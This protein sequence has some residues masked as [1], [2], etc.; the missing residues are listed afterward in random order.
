MKQLSGLDATFLYLESPQTPMHVGG[1]HLYALPK[2]FKGDFSKVVREH[3]RR[4]LHLAPIFTNRLLFMPFD[5]GHP[6]WR[7]DP[8][9]DLDYHIRR[10]SLPKPGTLAQLEAACAKLHMQLI[11]R[12]RPLWEFYVFTGLKTKQIGFYTKVHHAA[13]DG[14][15][16][17]ALANAVLDISPKPRTVAPRD[18]SRSIKATP[19][20]GV[21]TLL[22]AAF[23]NTLAQYAKI[24]RSLPAAASAISGAISK[25]SGSAKSGNSI[26]APRTVFNTSLSTQRV[27][28]TA[29]M[30]LSRAKSIGKSLEASLN[31]VV[32]FVCST[33][34][35]NYLLLH[36]ALPRKS[37]VAAMPVSLRAAGDKE[38]NNQSSMMLVSLGT[39]YAEPKRRLTAI[40]EST[41]KIKDGLQKLKSLMPTD[42]PSLLAPW[43]VGGIASAYNRS[44]IASSLPMPANVVISNVPGPT[45][46]LFLAGAQML[47]FHPVSIIVH[48]IALNITVQSYAGSIDFGLIACKKA[49]PDL[50]KL[51]AALND[52]LDELEALV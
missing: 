20:P 45:A 49:V 31:D 40:L 28:V 33:A 11:D 4:R 44:G 3:I 36:D 2:G 10:V 9:V 48:G 41:A 52:A 8:N 17:T 29:A 50:R 30:D 43:L 12:N 47:T 27:F 51:A 15:A 34:L 5:I 19:I 1:L 7:T 6:A 16:G 32:L 18:A 35:R 24:V 46:P 22:S 25:S 14:Q 38:L 23:S 21:G 39:Q 42:Y 37:L 13:L 26:L